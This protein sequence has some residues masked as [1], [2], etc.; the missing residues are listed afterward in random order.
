MIRLGKFNRLRIAK[1]RSVGFFFDGGEDGDILMPKRHQPEHCEVGDELDVF[2]FRDAEERLT[3]TVHK[4]LA[5]VGEV[6]WLRVID[7]HK[8]GAFLD[9]GVTKD[10]LVP[11]REQAEDMQVG[12]RYLVYIKV[13]EYDRIIGSTK[14]ENYL[15]ETN[16]KTFKVGQEV[17]LLI[18]ENT[19]LGFRAVINNSHLGMLYHNELFQKLSSGQKLKGYIKKIRDDDKLDLSLQPQGYNRQHFTDLGAKILAEIEAQG[20]FLPLTDKSSPEEIQAIFE[21]SKKAFKQAVGKLYKERRITI[22]TR[23]LKLVPK[24]PP[25][26]KAAAKQA[27]SK[28]AGAKPS[29][30][31]PASKPAAKDTQAASEQPV[32]AKAPKPPPR[33]IRTQRWDS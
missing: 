26:K 29:G 33:P 2:V 21:V 1:E 18:G 27:A 12:R 28:P 32:E 6:A 15:K 14:L 9:W 5:T 30:S 4:P 7:T 19:N 25:A 11:L 13:D 3:A 24:A 31:K 22:E 23:G 17:E 20:G 8:I 10:L 16:G